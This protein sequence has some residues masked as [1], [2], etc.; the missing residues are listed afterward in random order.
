MMQ[1]TAKPAR[2]WPAVFIAGVALLGA[3]LEL[4][5]PDGV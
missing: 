2:L 5:V 3:L 1:T 4:A